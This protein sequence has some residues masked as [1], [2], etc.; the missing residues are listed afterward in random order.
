MAARMYLMKLLQ[1][2]SSVVE[3]LRSFSYVKVVAM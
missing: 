2:L 1:F 3:V